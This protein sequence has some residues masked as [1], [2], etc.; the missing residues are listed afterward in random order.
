VG[1]LSFP[2]N[3]TRTYLNF[4]TAASH[5]FDILPLPFACILPDSGLMIK[6]ASLPDGQKI[7]AFLQA[8]YQ[9]L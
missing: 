6:C 4:F 1:S 7:Q 3:F 8:V 9:Y 2:S 5:R